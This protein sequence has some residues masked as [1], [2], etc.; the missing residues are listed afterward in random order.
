MARGRSRWLTL[1]ACAVGALFAAPFG[2]LAAEVAGRGP[3]F[4]GLAGPLARTLVLA[5]TV[6][7]A[8]TATGCAQAWLLWRTDLSGRRWLRPLAPLPLV[9]PSFVGAAALLAAVAPGGLIERALRPLGVGRLPEVAGFPGA[10]GVLWVLTVPYVYLPVSAR[11][12]ELPPS[13]E[14]TARLL[15]RRPWGVFAT[16]VAPQVLPAASSGALLVFLYVLSDFGA[17][18][19][20]RYD[21]LTRAIYAARLF[22]QAASLTASLVLGAAALVVVAGERAM[23]RRLPHVEAA[24][25]RAP[26]VYAL[27]RWAGPGWL[28]AAGPVVAG[29]VLP[30]AVLAWWAVRSTGGEGLVGALARRTGDLAVPAWHTGLVAVV[31][32]AVAVAVVLPVAYAAAR[33]RGRLAGLAG[34]LVLAGFA[35][36]G[37]VLALALVFFSLEAPGGAR[38]YQTLPLLIVAYVLHFGAQ[39]LGPARAAFAAAPRRLVEAAALLGAR[40]ARRFATVELPLLAPGLLAGAGLVLVS[41]MKELPATLLLAPIGFDTLA[42]RIWNAAEDGFLAEMAFA[43]CVLVALSLVLLR[44][45]QRAGARE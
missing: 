20:L 28:V 26:V 31:T 9:I 38:V 14:E 21:T 22:D 5:V 36:P 1:A 13:L 7:A 37:L 30:T 17:V 34:A 18:A 10:F 35:L 39:A 24:R 29:L 27:G 3:S 19:L 4:G 25:A 8:A 16:V 23:N 32:A 15:G 45:V 33:H 12:R 6:T 42:T 2:Y 40:P 44:P 41:T 11:L 43:A